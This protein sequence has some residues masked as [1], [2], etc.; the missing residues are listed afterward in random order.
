MHVS[1]NAENGLIT[2]LETTSGEA[3]DGH[4]FCSLVDHDLKQKLL[5]DTYAADK[6]YDDGDNH[7]YLELRGLHSAIRLMKTRIGKKDDNR[8][9]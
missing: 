6:G 5:L 7:Y 2:S 9:P 3:Y 1:L 4:H 8:Q